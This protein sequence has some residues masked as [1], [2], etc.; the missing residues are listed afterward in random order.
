MTAPDKRDLDRLGKK[1]DEARRRG[2]VRAQPAPPTS[3]GLAFRFTTE[4]VSALL[5]GGALGWFLDWV[6][7]LHFLVVVFFVL[8]AAAGI[9]NTMRAAAELNRQM[10][11]A[12]PAPAIKIDDDEES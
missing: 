6:F 8:G 3:L 4:M 10:A 1:L 11:Q 2:N 7:G 5:V 12:P 9:R